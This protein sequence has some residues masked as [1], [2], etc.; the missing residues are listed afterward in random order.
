MRCNDTIHQALKYLCEVVTWDWINRDF[1]GRTHAILQTNFV[2]V[3]MF[4]LIKV[5]KRIIFQSI[6]ITNQVAGCDD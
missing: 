2:L 1:L 5:K 3:N 4:V 6:C